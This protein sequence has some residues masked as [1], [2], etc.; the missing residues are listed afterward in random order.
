MSEGMTILLTAVLTAFATVF[1]FVAG[2]LIEHIFIEPVHE[3][4]RVIGRIAHALTFY[5]DIT[6]DGPQPRATPERVANVR[7][8]LRALAADLR[9]TL[10][11]LPWYSAF[12]CVRLALPRET[13]KKVADRL[14][15]W[16]LFMSKTAV[17]GDVAAVAKL[18]KIDYI[19]DEGTEF[20]ELMRADP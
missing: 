6:E 18:L 16:E 5:R 14:M 12:S 13:V 10:T 4:R 3:Q 19:K 1:T 2:R 8:E 17:A 11:V 9:S 15:H 7:S 20:Q